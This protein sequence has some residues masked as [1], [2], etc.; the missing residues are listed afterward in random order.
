MDANTR[1]ADSREA[2]MFG[3]RPELAAE[4]K[5]SPAPL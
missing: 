3:I 1:V 2:A 4:M 5:K